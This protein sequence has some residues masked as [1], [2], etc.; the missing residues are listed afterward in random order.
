M[1]GLLPSQKQKVK[2][3]RDDAIK[4]GLIKP[5]KEDIKESLMSE[6]LSSRLEEP[7]DYEGMHGIE[8]DVVMEVHPNMIGKLL[9]RMK[10]KKVKKQKPPKK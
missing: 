10:L 6:S 1:G 8:G 4:A 2:M 5:K 3:L 7:D 9:N